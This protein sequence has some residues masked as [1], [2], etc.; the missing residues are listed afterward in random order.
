MQIISKPYF[1]YL[2][3]REALYRPS[4]IRRG[5]AVFNAVEEIYGSEIARAVQFVDG[6]DCF[7]DD[8][9]IEKFLA[10]SYEQYFRLV[11]SENET[12]LREIFSNKEAIN[13]LKSTLE[14]IE[15]E[16]EQNNTSNYAPI[17]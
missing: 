7:Y 6:V 1:D 3:W 12:K 13:N 5:Q 16:H 4:F 9:Q 8:S 10:H 17:V 11:R 14:E 2:V 15:K